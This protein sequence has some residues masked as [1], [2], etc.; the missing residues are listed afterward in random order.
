MKMLFKDE[1]IGIKNKAATKKYGTHLS[2]CLF[3]RETPIIGP[4][5]Y[6]G[7]D[8]NSNCELS[9]IEALRQIIADQYGK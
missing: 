2:H 3:F 5:H 4:L 7:C 9:E 6:V 1:L 8:D